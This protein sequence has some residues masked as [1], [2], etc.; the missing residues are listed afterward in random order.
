VRLAGHRTNMLGVSA[1]DNDIE[2]MEIT[3]LRYE[4]LVHG[5]VI[6]EVPFG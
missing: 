4:R 5:S 1:Q 3:I 2:V 6:R